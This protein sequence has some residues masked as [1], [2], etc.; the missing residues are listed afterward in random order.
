VGICWSLV[1]P[2]RR[3]YIDP[4]LLG[5]RDKM[6]GVV[7]GPPA[8]ALAMLVVDSSLWTATGRWHGDPIYF[9]SDSDSEIGHSWEL[10]AGGGL[11][12][13]ASEECTEISGILDL[14]VPDLGRV[15]LVNPARRECLRPASMM[16]A[17]GELGEA[18]TMALALLVC[19]AH[20]PQPTELSSRWH[21]DDVRL[22]PEESVDPDITDL[23]HRALLCLGEYAPKWMDDWALR[24]V[25]D[26]RYLT[27]LGF[28]AAA[29]RSAAV[30]APLERHLGRDWPKR[31]EEA[32]RRTT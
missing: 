1:N 5:W 29:T 11:F 17:D 15:A 16:A 32:F 31:Y 19:Q 2:A 10:V 9:S 18:A 12:A 30:T 25:D 14:T 3:E 6:G 8:H 13:W 7:D 23:S 4:H 26:N 24:A 27:D 22:V 21:G 28:V 20:W